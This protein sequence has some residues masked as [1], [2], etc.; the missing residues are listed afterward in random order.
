MLGAQ[1]LTTC[2][3]VGPLSFALVVSC[4]GSEKTVTGQVTGVVE[5]N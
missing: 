2:L 5:R 1:G 3:V 4:R